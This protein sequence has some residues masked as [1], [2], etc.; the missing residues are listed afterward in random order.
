MVPRKRG[1]ET[2]GGE[3]QGLKGKQRK[4]KIEVVG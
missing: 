3:D 1:R 2:E 4:D